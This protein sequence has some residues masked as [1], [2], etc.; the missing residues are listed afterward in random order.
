MKI[1]TSRYPIGFIKGKDCHYSRFWSKLGTIW[2]Y[3]EMDKTFIWNFYFLEWFLK[4]KMF[5]Y[6]TP[7][8]FSFLQILKILNKIH[9]AYWLIS[10]WLFEAF[11]PVFVQTTRSSDGWN[12]NIKNLGSKPRLCNQFFD[13]YMHKVE[14]KK[15]SFFELMS[16]PICQVLSN[17]N[18][19]LL[20]FDILYLF[21]IF[22]N[23]PPW[24]PYVGPQNAVY[25]LFGHLWPFSSVD[26]PSMLSSCWTYVE[27]ILFKFM[28][29]DLTIIKWKRFH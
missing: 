11:E 21:M 20:V 8:R 29:I 15:L 1:P 28:M 24:S 4:I 26:F 10:S 27:H 16:N 18:Y 5:F 23:P 2:A 22:K 14:K 12:H 17:L 13:I 19:S 7:L 6:H 25:Q 9:I 3:Y